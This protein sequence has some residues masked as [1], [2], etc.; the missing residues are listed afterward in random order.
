MSRPATWPPAGPARGAIVALILGAI[1]IAFS[2]IFAKLSELG[3]S[4]TAFH[5]FFIALPFLWAW[6][7]ATAKPSN[8]ATAALGR[9]DRLHLMLA[10]LFL[11]FDIA[12]WH[13]ALKLGTVTNGTLLGNTAPVW[14]VIF[15]WLLLGQRFTPL[16]LVGLALAVMGTAILVGG[17][18][19]L[20]FEHV[21]GDALG[22]TAGALYAAY[23]I[24]LGR[25]RRRFNTVTVMAW[26][27]LVCSVV[28]L[29]LALVSGESLLPET[30]RGWAVLLG[31]A[32]LVQIIG[33]STIGWAM[34]HLTTAFAAVTLL[35][36][37]I[38][39]MVLA[40]LILREPIG[41]P[42]LLGG[43]IVLAGIVLARRGG[44]EETGN[45]ASLPARSD[46]GKTGSMAGR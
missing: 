25:A 4:A 17:S 21:A 30:W 45:K 29:P 10:G 6:M 16:F 31:L 41:V 38:A 44:P 18:F 43:A 13:W 7:S 34:A 32:V 14:V 40:W 42:Q 2:G 22:L 26:T 27:S 8:G 36:N 33:H 35:V 12:V 9:D 24:A 11:G 23:L 20:S 1:I 37:P 19:T 15:G 39:T 5:R 28:L 46:S 3:P